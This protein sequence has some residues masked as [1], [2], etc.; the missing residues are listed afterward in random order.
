MDIEGHTIRVSGRWLRIGR[1]DTEKYDYLEDPSTTISTV[2]LGM[3]P[4]DVFTFIEPPA[5]RPRQ[6][7]YV[8]ESDNL[9]VIPI[10][11]FDDWWKTRVNNKTRNMVR[12]G[13]KLGLEAR[14]VTFSTALAGDVK[15]IYDETPLRQGKRFAHY[16]KPLQYISEITATHLDRSILIGA[17]DGDTLAG[18]CKLMLS[19]NGRYAGVMHLLSL[20]SHRDKAPS[21]ALIAQAVRSCCARGVSYLTYSNFAYGRKTSDSLSDFKFHNGFRR[22]DVPRYYVPI[23]ARGSLGLRLGLHRSM[24]EYVPA[25]LQ[26][27][28][29][30]LRQH[31]NRLTVTSEAQGS[32]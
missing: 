10:T 6:L 28:L 8:V 23:T 24:H 19:R 15:R 12:R 14:E 7:D 17:Y 21:N 20:L 13:E 11:S 30:R 27:R 5:E 2:A 1:L 9:A 31:W 16:Q 18:F 26:E 4:M 32:T 3:H 22:V 25:P 29:R